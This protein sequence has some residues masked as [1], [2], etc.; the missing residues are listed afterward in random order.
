MV[1][2]LLSQCPRGLSGFVGARSSG[3]AHRNAEKV[4]QP[5]SGRR[6][7]PVHP[8]DKNPDTHWPDPIAQVTYPNARSA[9][10]PTRSGSAIV[11]G[12]ASR[13]R[14]RV[15]G[16]GTTS[17]AAAAAPT[18]RE[19]VSS[20]AAVRPARDYGVPTTMRPSSRRRR[21]SS[22]NPCSARPCSAAARRP[23][24]P[25]SSSFRRR[26]SHAS[27]RRRRRSPSA[28]LSAG[29]SA[30][31]TRAGRPSASSAAGPE[32]APGRAGRSVGTVFPTG[33][34]FFVRSGVQ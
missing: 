27:S 10:P 21:R 22:R 13:Q 17:R 31:P 8:D 2:D 32:E 30:S 20:G 29:P 28:R 26:P 14:P 33:W 24:A 19:P 12:L 25:S 16:G 5:R 7:A 11:S 3:D 1:S 18:M 15:A 23:C 34:A 4:D 9:G 6:A